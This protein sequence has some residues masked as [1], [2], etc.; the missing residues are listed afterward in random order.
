MK[1]TLFAC[2]VFLISF[3]ARA[4]AGQSMDSVAING[5]T[6]KVGDQVQLG[7]GSGASGRFVFFEVG[8]M[9]RS[10]NPD[11]NMMPANMAGLKVTI[12]KIKNWKTHGQQRIYFVTDGDTGI[13]NGYLYIENAI[14][15]GEVESIH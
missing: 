8:G 2:L 1:I 12:K 4:Q 6:Y 13:N 3:N 11:R 7:R 9:A 5:T 14:R 10:T 15:A